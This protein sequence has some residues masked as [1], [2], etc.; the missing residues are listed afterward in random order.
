MKILK[1]RKFRTLLLSLMIAAAVAA[2]LQGCGSESYTFNSAPS[3]S[4]GGAVTLD[5]GA[6][7]T[8]TCVASDPDGDALT[9]SWTVT[10]PPGK[11]ASALL[12]ATDIS[13]PVFTPDADD[14]L[15]VLTVTVSDGTYTESASLSVIVGDVSDKL[16]PTNPSISI[17]R[18]DAFTCNEYVKVD[19]GAT[20][21]IG[22]VAYYLSENGTAPTAGDAGWVSVAPA[23]VYSGSGISYGMT[24]GYE[25]KTIYVWFM[26]AAGNISS[27][28]SD[29][30]EYKATAGCGQCI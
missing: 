19:I 23:A 7:A 6:T 17:N 2:F 13:N 5:N 24:T 28:A 9:Y 26:D 3:V 4:A 11:D 27:A 1:Q 21:D 12:S 14:T 29:D 30:I 10:S 16:A 18:G 15:Y 25:I 8:L 22:V 20:D